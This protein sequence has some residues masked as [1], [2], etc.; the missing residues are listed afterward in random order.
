MVLQEDVFWAEGLDIIDERVFSVFSKTD[1][2]I[3]TYFRAG[4]NKLDRA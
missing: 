1:K 3:A 2:S 4:Q